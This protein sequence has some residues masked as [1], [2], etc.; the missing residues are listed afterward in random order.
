MSYF[1][2]NFNYPHGIMFHHFH[3]DKKHPKTQGSIS[4]KSFTKIIKFIGRKNILNP[5]EFFNAYENKNKK[6]LH[7]WNKF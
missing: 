7:I 3:D 6:P 2:K 5:K 4:A 1:K